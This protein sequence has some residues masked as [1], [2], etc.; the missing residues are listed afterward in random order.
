[1]AGKK[2]RRAARMG[3]TMSTL[4]NLLKKVSDT[5]AAIAADLK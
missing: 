3:K 4:S 1:M 2:R 5:A